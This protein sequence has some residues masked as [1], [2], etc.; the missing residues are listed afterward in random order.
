V[1]F[2]GIPALVHSALRDLRRKALERR[3]RVSRETT[4]RNIGRV[5]KYLVGGYGVYWLLDRLGRPR[6]FGNFYYKDSVC[7]GCSYKEKCKVKKA[8]L[9][10]G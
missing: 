7:K 4:D 10:K 9:M 3:T 2:R 5:S 6:C 8:E 1:K